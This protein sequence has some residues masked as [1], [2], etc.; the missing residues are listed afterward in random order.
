MSRRLTFLLLGFL[1]LLGVERS[2]AIM[3]VDP[4][5]DFAQNIGPGS[6]TWIH[7]S[8]V[9]DGTGFYGRISV[10]TGEDF[11]F[12]V[13]DLDGYN[14]VQGGGIATPLYNWGHNIV[15]S[16]DF[17]YIATSAA[18]LY[19]CVSNYDSIF[20]TIH[21]AGFLC[22]DAT[23]PEIDV[24]SPSEGQTVSGTIQVEATA[25]DNAFQVSTMRIYIDNV[26]KKTVNGESI[27]YSW[28]TKGVSNTAHAVKFYA[29]DN[30]NNEQYLTVNVYV[31]NG[32]GGNVNDSLS[33]LM[34][35]G[36]V[37]IIA[38]VALVGV[39]AVSSRRKQA[40]AGVAL[41][42][43]A[44]VLVVCPFCGTK[45]EQGITTCAHCGAKV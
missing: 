16:V 15:G 9:A 35:I 1:I 6:W 4:R 11:D 44:K 3:I 17:T 43:G 41:M 26:L 31:S 18:D 10:N 23:A 40:L 42:T 33:I 20:T 13:C 37:G 2:Q 25:T 28:D 24:V 36:I 39:A 14:T 45:N 30:V 27:T 34:P 21:A 7:A 29:T 12:F 5:Y 22:R 32:G 38:I 8:G 19:W